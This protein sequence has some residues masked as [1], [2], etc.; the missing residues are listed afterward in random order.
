MIE[1]PG[2]AYPHCLVCG[3]PV[4]TTSRALHEITGYEREREQGGTNH[5]I[6]RKR[7][8]RIVGVCCAQRVQRGV[9]TMQ[10]ALL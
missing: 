9:S 6:A 1:L 3:E 4:Q 8:G 2:N 5:V 7:T 10:E